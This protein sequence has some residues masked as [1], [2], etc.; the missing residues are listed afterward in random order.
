ML[1]SLDLTEDEQYIYGVLI[2]VVMDALFIVP[3]GAA[4]F[5]TMSVL[6]LV[7][8][9]ALFIVRLKLIFV[10]QMN[11][12]ILVVMDALLFNCQE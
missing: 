10:P 3:R 4:V 6:I 11:V 5:A 12:L 9:D 7:V 2:L 8:M 1:Y